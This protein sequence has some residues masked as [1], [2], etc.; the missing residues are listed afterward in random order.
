MK[1]KRKLKRPWLDSKLAGSVDKTIKKESKIH[2]YIDRKNN[3]DTK[4]QPTFQ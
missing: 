4:K 1:K 2:H 3:R